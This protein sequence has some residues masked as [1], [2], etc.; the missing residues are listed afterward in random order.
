M[1]YNKST[2]ELLTESAVELFS[3]YPVE[4]ISI[5]DIAKN[6]GLS[7]RTFYNYFQDKYELITWVY[8]S[9]L[10]RY[11]SLHSYNIDFSDFMYFYA[12]TIYDNISFYINVSSYK[13]QNN[14]RESLLIPMRSIYLRIIQEVYHDETTEEI[15]TS[16]TFF[17]HGSINYIYQLIESQN[18]ISPEQATCIFEKNLPANLK[19][20]LKEND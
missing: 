9:K 7:S 13:G 10:E 4:K 11:Y 12:K 16:L 3:K 19:K 2:K 6:C 18:I 5:N 17:L 20:Y 8:I 14:L 1:I 15:Y